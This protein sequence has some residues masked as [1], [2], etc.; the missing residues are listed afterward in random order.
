MNQ[1]SLITWI[2]LLLIFITTACFFPPML[3]DLVD[4]DENFDKQ[5]V[6]QT[7]AEMPGGYTV[8]SANGVEV[9]LPSYFELGEVGTA[10]QNLSGPDAALFLQIAQS[11]QLEPVLWAYSAETHLL[12]MKNESYAA[13]PLAV[14]GPVVS[15]LAGDLADSMTQERISLGERDAIRYQTTAQTSGSEFGQVVYLFKD[16]GKL[17]VLGFLSSASQVSG[18]LGAFDAAAASFTVVE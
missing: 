5:T 4:S 14:V 12:V 18:N 9:T 7:D 2:S 17:W 15:A 10:M 16:S 11:N 13:L 6:D 8:F 1:K 3:H